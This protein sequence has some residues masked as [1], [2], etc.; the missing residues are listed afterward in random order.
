MD[1][2]WMLGISG[3]SG[4]SGVSRAKGVSGE[5]LGSRTSTNAKKDTI[6]SITDSEKSFGYKE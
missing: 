2:S 6:Q 5:K 1:E 3:V 4:V